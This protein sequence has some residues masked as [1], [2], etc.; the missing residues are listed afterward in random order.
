MMVLTRPGS[1]R[2]LTVN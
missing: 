1:R 2:M